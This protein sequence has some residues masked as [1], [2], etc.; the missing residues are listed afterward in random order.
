MA[1]AAE[2][3][4]P[5][6]I[7]K[8]QLEDRT[9]QIQG[10]LPAHIPVDRFK[11]TAFTAAMQN[12]DLLTKC[13]RTSL[14]NAVMKAATDGLLPDAREGAIVEFKGRAQWMPMIAGLRKKVRQSGEIATWQAEV[15]YENDHFDYQ[16]GD[17]PFIRHTPAL[18]NRGEVIAAYSIATLKSG[19]KS[20]EVMSIEDIEKVREVSRAW[21]KGPWVDWFE[22]MAKKTVARRHSKVLPMNT[23]LDTVLA[24]DNT[25]FGAP[26]GAEEGQ[27]SSAPMKPARGLKAKLQ[28]L[29]GTDTARP[30]AREPVA[31][32]KTPEP[33]QE[34]EEEH[35]VDDTPEPGDIIDND[36]GE[37]IDDEPHVEQVDPIAT[38]HDR[39]IA[40]RKAGYQRKAV[41][42]EYR[43]E[44]RAA[45]AEAWAAGWSEQHKRLQ[46]AKPDARP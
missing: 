15:V 38:A 24:R 7:W 6:A 35:P 1:R 42:P 41:P 4:N 9:D 46:S 12:P 20:R 23:D 11:R 45:E 25:V 17:E 31:A 5:L 32:A 19:E 37:I 34:R 2:G 13:D 18:R 44:D 28:V 26:E 21:A 3:I 8:S 39:G 14:F 27:I 29:A 16:L 30:P 36:T 33:V 43:R 10:V 22:E 40:A